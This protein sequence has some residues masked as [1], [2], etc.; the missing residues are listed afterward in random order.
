MTKLDDMS[1]VDR[2]LCE[3]CGTHLET[4]EAGNVTRHT[5]VH[6]VGLEFYCDRCAGQRF[7]GRPHYVAE[8][9]GAFEPADSLRH[10]P[11]VWGDRR[12]TDAATT[13]VVCLAI[14]AIVVA[15]VL[16]WGWAS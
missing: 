11:L 10:P 14:A 5:R 3:G 2:I 8:K 1:P 9:D 15:G 6:V 16:I 13:V 4:I 12:T 7:K